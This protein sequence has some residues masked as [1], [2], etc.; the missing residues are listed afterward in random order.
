MAQSLFKKLYSFDRGMFQPQRMANVK[1]HI[2]PAVKSN[3]VLFSEDQPWEVRFDNSYPNVFYDDLVGKYRCY[4][5]TFT[6]DPESS[7]Y[8]KEQR[9]NRNYKPLT[10][11]IVSLCYAESDDGITWH[12]PNLGLT[13]FAGST[14]NNIIGHYLHGTSV[15]LDR[16]DANPQRRYKLFTKIDYGN[17]VHFLAV[18]FSADGINFSD[19]KRININPR[20]DT[21][22]HVIYDENLGCYVL[23]TRTWRDGVRIPSISYSQDFLEWTPA[24]GI[25][26]AR[27][28]ENQVYSMPMFQRG[29]YTLGLASV[30]HEGDCE[31]EDF[32]QVDLE[33]CYVYRNNK[34][35]RQWNYVA[36]RQAIIARGKGSYASEGDFDAGCIY[37][38]AP[39]FK[40]NGE[41]L[42]YYV[43]GNGQH[44]NFR[45]G[46][47][48]YALVAQDR[49][50]FYQPKD[51]QREAV[52]FTN[53]LVVLENNIVIDADIADEGYLQV[54]LYGKDYQPL[55]LE[56]DVMPLSSGKY[57]L[58][59][60]KLP[61][62][63]AV[64]LA[65][66]FMKTKIYSI[67]GSLDVVRV[68]A[69]NTLLRA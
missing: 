42:I 34:F 38:S 18:A 28:Y 22:N 21:H 9:R 60:S 2:A 10:G 56:V 31:A 52:L 68:E 25:L 5:S 66:R 59:L 33:L 48:S 44:T 30:M 20:A 32:D 27:G 17:G 13:E 8:S 1:L 65:L 29:D 4:Y 26:N 19:Y 51:E 54:Q 64:K 69:E 62:L 37:A 39:I 67:E 24:V 41:A 7:N 61:R 15:F 47:L 23:M 46:H 12:K 49:W 36:P 50:S 6:Y 57:R 35:G 16:H 55:D 3:Q 63:G 40:E 45:E 43:G 53:D 58:D 14:A 11:R